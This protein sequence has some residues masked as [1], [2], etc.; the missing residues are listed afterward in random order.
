MANLAGTNETIGKP[1]AT[2]MKHKGGLKNPVL[3]VKGG[4]TL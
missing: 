2:G 3:T 4:Q 1:H